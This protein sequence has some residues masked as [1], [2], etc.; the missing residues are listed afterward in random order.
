MKYLKLYKI[1]ESDNIEDQLDTIKDMFTDITDGYNIDSNIYYHQESTTYLSSTGPVSKKTDYIVIDIDI[2][3]K[4]GSK[5]I[6]RNL[7]KDIFSFTDRVVSHFGVKVNYCLGGN[8]IINKGDHIL[9]NWHNWE[10]E[11]FQI[12][13]TQ[14]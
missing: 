12:Y 1:F 10:G 13:F 9:K 11:Y 5:D 14:E 3:K 7:L 8:E 6:I 4:I 2:D